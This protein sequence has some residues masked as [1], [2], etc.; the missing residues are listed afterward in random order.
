[1]ILIEEINSD[2]K[3]EEIRKRY[4]TEHDV[5][6]WKLWQYENADLLM[7]ERLTKQQ[8]LISRKTFTKYKLNH[9]QK[10]DYLSQFG[11][12]TGIEFEWIHEAMMKT[13]DD[14]HIC[15]DPN[16][17]DNY[18]AAT[19]GPRCTCHTCSHCLITSLKSIPPQQLLHELC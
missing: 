10:C 14:N 16:K 9:V 15:G 11:C 1:M 13:L 18:D 19:M 5:D 4:H 2:E 3:Y 6:L 17:C 8:P 12:S 7:R